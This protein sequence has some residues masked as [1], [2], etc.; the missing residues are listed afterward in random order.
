MGTADL[1]IDRIFVDFHMRFCVQHNVFLPQQ[2]NSTA[3][4]IEG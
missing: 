3:A 4:R 1:A 2:M